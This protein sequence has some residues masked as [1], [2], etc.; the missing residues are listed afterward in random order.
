MVESDEAIVQEMM[1]VLHNNFPM[2]HESMEHGEKVLRFL[3]G[4]TRN[5]AREIGKR[6]RAKALE[7][8]RE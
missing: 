6:I 2:T 8:G 3:V 1:E 5:D 4:K 7:E